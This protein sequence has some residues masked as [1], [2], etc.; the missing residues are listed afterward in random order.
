M[1]DLEE[2]VCFRAVCCALFFG[3]FRVSE[4]LGDE[5]RGIKPMRRSQVTRVGDSYHLRLLR[6]KCSDQPTVVKISAQPSKHI[7]PVYALERFMRLSSC[8]K[9]ALFKD[10][11]SRPLTTQRFRRQ[12]SSVLQA[13]GKPPSRYPPHSFRIGAATYAAAMGL[14]D[15]E[16]RQLGRWRSSAFL[17]YVRD[18]RT[19]SL[20]TAPRP[21]WVKSTRSSPGSGARLLRVGGSSP[22]QVPNMSVLLIPTS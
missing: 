22:S 14:S 2:Y 7:C 11:S 8:S 16:I 3:F 18:F 20:S 12:L 15:A 19:L 9:G 17:R 5:R 10:S 13:M 4:V 1:M 21:A 6:S